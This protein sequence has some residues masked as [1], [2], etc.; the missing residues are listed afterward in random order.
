M[1]PGAAAFTD[2]YGL[3]S[4]TVSSQFP[5]QMKLEDLGKVIVGVAPPPGQNVILELTTSDGKLP[6]ESNIFTEKKHHFL[7]ATYP[8]KL[9]SE[10]HY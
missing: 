6:I 5:L 10:S 1:L 9:W 4:D 8:I 3:K 2:I 7:R